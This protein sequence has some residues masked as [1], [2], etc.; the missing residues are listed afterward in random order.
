MNVRPIIGILI[1][2]LMLQY[3]MGGL[4]ANVVLLNDSQS[5][6]N[7]GT[8]SEN[9][10]PNKLN[11]TAAITT[12]N[13]NK[14]PLNCPKWDDYKDKYVSLITSF[15]QYLSDLKEYVTN[16]Q[17]ID[18]CNVALSKANYENN[19]GYYSGSPV[20]GDIDYR[21]MPTSELNEAYLSAS[22]AKSRITIANSLST[23]IL[24]TYTI[25]T[26]VLG[27]ASAILSIVS[28]IIGAVTAATGGG[29]SPF[30]VVCITLTGLVVAATIG[31]GTCTGLMTTASS[32]INE[33]SS[34][35]ESRLISMNAELI[36]RATLP[37]KCNSNLTN[38][39]VAVFNQ[40]NMTNNSSEINKTLNNT[41]NL[42]TNADMSINLQNLT[43]SNGTK[44][45]TTNSTNTN[46]T[47][48]TESK[49]I[50]GV[51]DVSP[52]TAPIPGNVT[53]A[54]SGTYLDEI[55]NVDLSGFPQEP[56]KPHPKWWQFWKWIEYGVQYARWIANVAVWGMNH[57]EIFKTILSMSNRIIADSK[58]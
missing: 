24:S 41:T 16:Y 30:L 9:T 34:K 3:S 46:A 1:I 47:N 6:N 7:S 26:I 4:C 56:S 49:N 48:G 17:Q 25:I 2:C 37:V 40:T 18:D 14:Y 50:I 45:N 19:T 52:S 22:L 11:A 58:C 28:T 35:I 8:V 5:V 12:S 23:N 53:S 42:G 10:T 55:Y 31:V 44:Q 51:N 15:R 54:R 21:Y 33:Q 39:T 36:Y 29:T 57:T 43:D 27:I 38:A 20:G 13:Y 32:G